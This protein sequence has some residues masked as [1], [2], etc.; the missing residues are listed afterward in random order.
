M[1]AR[2]LVLALILAG[3]ALLSSTAQAQNAPLPPLVAIDAGHGGIDAGAA[4]TRDGKRYVE[5]DLALTLARQVSDHLQRSGYRVMLT[6]ASNAAVNG[7]AADTTGDGKVDV[8]DELQARIDLANGA[9]ASVLVSIHFNGSTE[10]KLRGPEVYYSPSRAFAGENRRLADSVMGAIARHLGETEPN[11]K[12]RGVQRDS[13]LGGHLF[14]LGPEGGR[15]ARASRMPAVLIEGLFL[16]NDDDLSVLARPDTVDRLARA[17]AEGV[18]SYLGPPPKA[19]P[20][21]GKVAGTGGANLRPAPLLGAAPIAVL[22]PGTNVEL[23]EAV[24][25]DQVGGA[26]EWWRINARGQAGFVFAPLI[27]AVAGSGGGDDGRPARDVPTSEP[28]RMTV[29]N[30]DGLPA[31]VRARP[32]TQSTIVARARPG[33][34]VEFVEESNG[35][36]VGG[37]SD[38][39]IRVRYQSTVGWVWAPL[40]A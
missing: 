13:I 3:S 26:S 9:S 30:D 22:P 27:A 11:L 15:I 18:A 12:P 8:A 21:R 1:A 23:I 38:R 16:T 6:R 7:K 35:E 32:S 5:R 40:L 2:R 29:R 19:A 39:W 34:S 37:G 28:R 17:Y 33:E 14:L 4:G 31:R 25:G 24:K 36:A 20:R 10:R